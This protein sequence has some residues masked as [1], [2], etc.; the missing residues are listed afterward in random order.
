MR[1]ITKLPKF[2]P[3][4]DDLVLILKLIHKKKHYELLNLNVDISNN[5]LIHYKLEISF[6]STLDYGTIFYCI[7]YAELYNV[8]DLKTFQF[9]ILEFVKN[10]NQNSSEWDIFFNFINFKTQCYDSNLFIHQVID[11]DIKYILSVLLEMKY[12]ILKHKIHQLD[13]MSKLTNHIIKSNDPKLITSFATN[14]P[15]DKNNLFNIVL[16]CKN[17]KYI[18]KYIENVDCE[19]TR[20]YKSLL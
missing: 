5:N 18:Y 16:S 17:K 10:L 7:R 20:K 2:L 14:F 12:S 4:E 13:I 15:S 19:N 1:S 8:F 9:K 3:T 6:L 11:L